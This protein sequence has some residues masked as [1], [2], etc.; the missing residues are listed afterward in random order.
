MESKTK[1]AI[2]RI[3]DINHVIAAFPLSFSNSYP[4]QSSFWAIKRLD[5]KIEE[6]RS[7]KKFKIFFI[8]DLDFYRQ[9]D[10]QQV[11]ITFPSH[12]PSFLHSLP[13]SQ[14][15]AF[16]YHFKSFRI[17]RNH[18][19]SLRH[20][21]RHHFRHHFRIKNQCALRSLCHHF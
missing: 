13:L 1:S 20:H 17:T 15:L 16:I 10:V 11:S 7:E 9:N 2:N 8:S 14:G 4:V 12:S 3:L 5:R 19:D 21:L 6:N 18:F